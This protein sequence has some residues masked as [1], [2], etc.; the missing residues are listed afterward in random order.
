[1]NQRQ[2]ILV[3]A[4]QPK[5]AD[6]MTSWAGTAGYD[7]TVVTTFAGAKAQLDMVP[8]LLIAE[9]KLA[10]YNGLHLVLRARAAGIPAIII[11]PADP[12]L[13]REAETFGAVYLREGLS[14]SVVLEA[15][16]R[17]LASSAQVPGQ[18][19]PGARTPVT[20][21]A[22]EAEMIW[23]AFSQSPSSETYR[24]SRSGLPN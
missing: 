15:I 3:V 19:Q 22:S 18:Y 12:V 6:R 1:M 16:H 9:L 4:Q 20:T 24:F 2:Q 11:G 23:R 8:D 7:V 21:V 10:E 5:V 14:R 17:Q 13:E